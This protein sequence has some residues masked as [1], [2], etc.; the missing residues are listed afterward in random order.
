M[1]GIAFKLIGLAGLLPAVAIAQQAQSDS[2][3]GVQLKEV[4]I[5]ARKTTEDL[6][7]A[8]I[9][10]TTVSA[11]DIARE[12]I[13]DATDLQWKLPAIEFQVAQSV[14]DVFIRGVGT[15]DLQAGVDSAVAFSIDGIYLAH[16]SAYPPVLVDIAQVEEVRGPQGTLY[17]RN[18]NGGALAFDSNKPVLNRWDAE[19]SLGAGNYGHVGSDFMLN[20]P[21]GDTVSTRFAFGTDKHNPY[22]SNGAI[23]G[24]NFTG[25]W[26]TLFQPNEN[27]DLIATLDK[28]RIMTNE[29]WTPDN[30]APNSNAPQ[31]AGVPFRPWTGIGPHNPAD[32]T[33]TTTWG[34]YLEANLR[35]SWA[36]ITSL[37]GYRDSDWHSHLTWTAGTAP[38]GYNPDGSLAPGEYNS[39][40]TQGENARNTT[41][42]IRIASPAGSTS[43]L[44]WI[45]GLYYSHET[46]P[47]AESFITNNAFGFT[48]T[49]LLKDDSKA[50]FGQ[51]TYS[52]INGLRL[53]GGLRFT[54][55]N[56]SAVGEQ[57]GNAINLTD[58]LRRVTWKAGV[59]YD[60]TPSSLLYGSVS[61]GF[62][63]GGVSEIPAF[64]P[65]ANQIY[66]PETIT[67]Y[68]IGNKNRFADN[69]IQVNY[70]L[71]YYDYKGFQ[72]LQGVFDENLYLETAN[73]QK[74]TMYGGELELQVALS[75]QDRLTLT[76]TGLH[77]VFDKF[78]VGSGPGSINY[79]GH[80]IEAAPPWT[81][82]GS[83]Q[84]EFLLPAS[85]KLVFKINTDVVGGH[86][87]D[88]G[89]AP[90]SFQPTYTRSTAALTYET[91]DGH[92]SVSAYVRNL[93]NNAAMSF[94]IGNVSLA[95]NVNFYDTVGVTPP[96]TYG[97]TVRWHL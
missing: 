96:R 11:E 89:N 67:A 12:G 44:S 40:F 84:H 22:W 3:L 14:P 43:S 5:T 9:A 81:I 80:H 31:C 10:V 83:Y 23:N 82:G 97:L 38:Y 52:I 72:T 74:A 4:V 26:R 21:L 35:L 64:V 62:K 36:T 59:D 30:C 6:Q 77:A 55:E 73:S 32:F 94:Y 54:D 13:K 53:T 33:Y 46:A 68:Q 91:G 34:A 49:P 60:L 57:S 27:F 37:T 93:E 45:M 58:V 1:R 88:N 69:R 95:E 76:P 41:Q 15:Y 28:S 29:S 85:D 79:D 61:T 19:A 20:V 78:E 56:K 90:G 7:K 50:I 18:S 48:S 17:G 65:G 47:Y 8:P 39:G 66:G 92:W 70:E 16:P 75:A 87:M 2:D 24:N 63:S 71:F 86:Y 51:L 25:R 42:E